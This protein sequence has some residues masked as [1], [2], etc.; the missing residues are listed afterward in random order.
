MSYEEPS[1]ASAPAELKIS[2]RLGQ[3]EL[4]AEGPD[5]AVRVVY[6]QFLDHLIHNPEEGATATA[7]D[8]ELSDAER[9][10]ASILV[11]E[12]LRK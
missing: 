4:H 8:E 12:N 6:E 3:S 5:V 9:Q 1:P 2:V 10:F 7:G 11:Q